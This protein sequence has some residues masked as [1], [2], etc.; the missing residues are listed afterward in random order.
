MT[1]PTEAGALRWYPANEAPD[2]VVV[3]TKI[4]DEKGV[5]N[6]QKLKRRGRLWFYDDGSMYVYYT[7]THYA[8]L[9]EAQQ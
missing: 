2:G 1:A 4:D 7:P 8:L 6:V 9:T 3:M 5:R